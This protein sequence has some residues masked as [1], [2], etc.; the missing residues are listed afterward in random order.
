[1][2]TLSRLKVIEGDRFYLVDSVGLCKKY[3]K[4]ISP[5]VE[6]LVKMSLGDVYNQFYAITLGT[7]RYHHPI[8]YCITELEELLDDIRRT[9][10]FGD[11]III[12]FSSLYFDDLEYDL[13]SESIEYIEEFLNDF[14]K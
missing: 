9:I 10:M 4:K 3:Y 13:S 7:E 14:V 11:E 8:E 2:I 1:M 12:T 5:T 6:T